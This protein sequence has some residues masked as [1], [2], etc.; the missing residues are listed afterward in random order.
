[1]HL[2]L[3]TYEV[4]LVSVVVCEPP[5]QVCGV[6]TRGETAALEGAQ[7][8]WCSRFGTDD[9]KEGELQGCVVLVSPLML[10]KDNGRAFELSRR[11]H[12][13]LINQ[14]DSGVLKD[15]LTFSTLRTFQINQADDC[16]PG[17]EAADCTHSCTEKLSISLKDET[18]R[19]T[20]ARGRGCERDSTWYQL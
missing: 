3:Q 11:W 6:K 4:H 8:R 15:V 2:C 17:R 10:G 12:S 20:A 19:T 14:T 18:C 9:I 5:V 13:C 7:G 1:M 16:C